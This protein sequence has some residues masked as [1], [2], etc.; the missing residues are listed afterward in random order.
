MILLSAICGNSDFGPLNL[1]VLFS[2]HYFSSQ[3]Q[4]FEKL[5]PIL[6]LN[7]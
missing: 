3:V 7:S 4:N 6:N 2:E 1:I 5:S